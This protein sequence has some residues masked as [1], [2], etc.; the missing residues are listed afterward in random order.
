MKSVRLCLDTMP[1]YSIQ[2]SLLLDPPT[3]KTKQ[4]VSDPLQSPQRAGSGCRKRLIASLVH[5][6]TPKPVAPQ[7]PRDGGS[8]NKSHTEMATA[9]HHQPLLDA[10]D[11]GRGTNRSPELKLASSASPATARRQ[12]FAS[13]N[14]APSKSRK[15]QQHARPSSATPATTW[16]AQSSSVVADDSKPAN[17]TDLSYFMPSSAV[18]LRPAGSLF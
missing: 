17:F 16:L 6:S 14:A 10:A 1:G 15:Q 11:Q 9:L 4:Q 18:V 5:K 13:Q 8:S 12:Q 3:K 7:A 2:S